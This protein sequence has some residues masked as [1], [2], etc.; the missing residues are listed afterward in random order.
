M[1]DRQGTTPSTEAQPG[2]RS[3]DCAVPNNAESGALNTPPL[4][5]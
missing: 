2:A 5:G 4:A 1:T 3:I